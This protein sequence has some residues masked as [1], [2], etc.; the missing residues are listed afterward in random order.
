[1]LV[2]DTVDNIVER[3]YS[4]DLNGFIR[5]AQWYDEDYTHLFDCR[6]GVAKLVTDTWC[7]RVDEPYWLDTQEELRSGFHC[8]VFYDIGMIVREL[9]TFAALENGKQGEFNSLVNE[10]RD[11]YQARQI[12]W[13][14]SLRSRCNCC[15]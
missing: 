1:M 14:R 8:L 15:K 2:I 11:L 10:L 12:C 4:L 7:Y 6:D 5:T 13:D 9:E 3:G